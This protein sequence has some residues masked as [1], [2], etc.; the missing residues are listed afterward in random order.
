MSLPPAWWVTAD[1]PDVQDW[2]AWFNSLEQAKNA[3]NKHARR[4]KASTGANSQTKLQWTQ[5]GNQWRATM[6][7]W[8]YTLFEEEEAENPKPRRRGK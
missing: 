3:C 8:S 2:K 7:D 1:G 6:G 5:S 4:H